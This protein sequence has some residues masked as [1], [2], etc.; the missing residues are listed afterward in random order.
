[1]DKIN[2]TVKSRKFWITASITIMAL[3]LYSSGQIDINRMTEII[4]I[5]TAIY[6]GSLSV[7]DGLTKLAPK[8]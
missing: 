2:E 4:G 7:I 8:E 1:M 6:V 3:G 5:A